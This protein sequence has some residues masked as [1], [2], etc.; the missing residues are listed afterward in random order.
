MNLE[1]FQIIV[2]ELAF[3]VD[4]FI[5]RKLISIWSNIS[6]DFQIETLPYMKIDAIIAC[7]VV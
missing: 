7:S 2:S 3:P 5:N 6:S 4:S 1:E